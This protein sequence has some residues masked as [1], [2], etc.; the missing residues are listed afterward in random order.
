M[1]VNN[2]VSINN[3][4]YKTNS[5]S[6]RQQM[7]FA[8]RNAVTNLNSSPNSYY[9]MISFRGSE[10]LKSSPLYKEYK[11]SGADGFYDFIKSADAE[12][13]AMYNFM[14]GITSDEK[15]SKSF[16]EEI[17]SDP[18]KSDEITSVLVD[19]IGGNDNFKRWYY[20]KDGYQRA[21]ERYFKKEIF[22]NDEV[23]VNDMVKMA[24]NVMVEAMQNKSLRTTGDK[25]FIIGNVPE[26]LGTIEDFRQIT[27]EVRGS[28]LV[29]EFI[30]FRDFMED[31]EAFSKRYPEAKEQAVNPARFAKDFIKVKMSQYRKSTD[32]K[33][34]KELEKEI[35]FLKYMN[36]T[37]IEVNGKK[38]TYS[39]ILRPYS[40]KLLFALQPEG[41]KNKYFVTMEMFNDEKDTCENIMN[42]ENSAMR[43][44]SPYLNA[45][46]DY[47]LKSNGCKSVPDMKFYDYKSNAVLY[48]F[49]Q[50]ESVKD[51]ARTDKFG[52]V[53]EYSALNNEMKP[54]TELGV[55]ITDCFFENFMQSG[56][57]T[58]IVDN[59]HAKFSNVLRPGV[60]MIHMGLQDLYGRDFITLDAGLNRASEL[61]SK[62]D[63]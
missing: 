41:T 33:E 9:N 21:Y 43:S 35:P 37:E 47:Y 54:L 4:N 18:R 46:V 29:K 50:G 51:E 22:E 3:L 48:P 52:V 12:P 14:L 16:I 36:D 11:M 10:A 56:D 5:V 19:K 24:P 2:I 15:A 31:T 59:G 55:F 58:L 23:S 62:N 57:E 63:K 13:D 30:K 38:Y 28:K 40:T 42:K 8:N 45:L 7:N 60:K 49:I 20:N 26:D 1:K 39:P 6:E 61:K 44:D 34:R 32:E 53:D 17:N 27:R 25:N